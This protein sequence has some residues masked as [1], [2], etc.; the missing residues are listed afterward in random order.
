LLS[1]SGPDA[2]AITTHSSGTAWAWAARSRGDCDGLGVRATSGAG[3][4]ARC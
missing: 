3:R 1:A 2:Q 4:A